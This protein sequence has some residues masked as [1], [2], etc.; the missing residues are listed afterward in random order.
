[1]SD[2]TIGVTLEQPFD[3][4]VVATRDSLAEQGFSVLTEIDVAATLKS[5]LDVDVAPQVILGACRAQL[6]HR[7]LDAVPPVATLLPCN[8]VVRDIGGAT[9]VEA[10]DPA[11]M[12]RSPTTRRWLR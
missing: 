2:Y 4:T 9:A 3:A 8:V 12:C 5:K 6:A 11:A 7:A 10:I 1:M